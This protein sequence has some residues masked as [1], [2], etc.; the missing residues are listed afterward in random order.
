[1]LQAVCINCEAASTPT[2]FEWHLTT[3]SG[4]NDEVA[5][6]A[7]W[8]THATEDSNSTSS[9]LTLDLAEV[10]EDTLTEEEYTLYATGTVRVHVDAIIKPCRRSCY[11]I[12]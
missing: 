3:T 9:H 6:D 12:H 11:L 5:V 1:M 8:Q 10:I 4:S 2:T 7:S